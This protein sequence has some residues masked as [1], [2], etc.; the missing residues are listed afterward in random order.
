M[1]TTAAEARHQQEVEELCVAA[2]RALSGQPDLHFRGRLLHRGDRRLPLHAPHLYPEAH[3]D[4]GSFRGA[5]DGMALRLSFSDADLH[6]T[7]TPL[8]T[9]ERALFEMLEQFRVESLVPARLAGVAANL[10]HRHERWSLSFHRSGL[11]ESARGLLLYTVTQVARARVTGEPVVE[12]TEDLL[13]AT[14][15]AIAPLLGEE[16]AALRRQ[17][18]DQRAYAEHAATIAHTVAG[19]L[20]GGEGAGSGEADDSGDS[21]MAEDS[22]DSDGDDAAFTLFVDFDESAE[23]FTPAGDGPSRVLNLEEQPYRVFTTAYDQQ[24]DIATLVR[25]DQ[26]RGFRET[27][28]RR[29]AHEG[30]NVW[31]LGR[32]LRAVLAEPARDG[33]DGGQDEGRVDGRRLAQLVTSPT[34]HRVFRTERIEPVA[35]CLVTF[36][37]DCSGSM[38][39]HAESVA[40]LVDVFGRALELADVRT[41]VLGFTTGTWHGGR[42]ARDWRRAGSPPHPG[43]LNELC[44][45]VFKDADTPWRLGRR[46]VAGLLRRDLFREGVDGEAVAWARTRMQARPEQRRILV[47]VSDGSPMDGATNLANDEHYLDSHLRQEVATCTESSDAEIV[48]VG[49]GRDLSPYYPRAQAL[50]LSGGVSNATVREVVSLLAGARQTPCNRG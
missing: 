6:R 46:G 14:R 16:L 33:W 22:A 42:A 17:R 12:E 7:L 31:R 5:A 44:H 15:A 41:E 39:E 11:T 24:R 27:L 48:G 28:D 2:I 47:V 26:L 40:V 9:V 45:I 20:T 49:V 3:E 19:M 13:E 29:V 43:R 25:A 8:G 21:D 38:K 36:L 50:D 10:R 1:Q 23:G 30:V 18:F 37:V 4:F 32:E 35:D 34:D